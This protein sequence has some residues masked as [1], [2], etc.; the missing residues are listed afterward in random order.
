MTKIPFSR[1]TFASAKEHKTFQTD[2]VAVNQVLNFGWDGIDKPLDYWGTHKNLICD[3]TIQLI[4]PDL[5]LANFS[6]IF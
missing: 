3:V 1:V 4:V 6:V 5:K 2:F